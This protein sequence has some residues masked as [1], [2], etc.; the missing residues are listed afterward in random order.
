MADFAWQFLAFL[1]VVG[2]IYIARVYARRYQWIRE[3]GLKP[4]DEFPHWVVIFFLALTVVVWPV[5][6]LWGM[7]NDRRGE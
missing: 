7:M 3:N 5:F 6:M 1:Y 2:A 4:G